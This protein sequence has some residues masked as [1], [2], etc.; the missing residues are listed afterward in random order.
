[1]T[2]I[3]NSAFHWCSELS[4]ITIPNGVSN[5]GESA[6]VDCDSLVKVEFGSN[7]KLETIDEYAFEHCGL[8]EIVIPRSVSEIEQGAFESCSKLSTVYYNGN[9]EEWDE[10]YIGSNND[11]LKN[12]TKKF[13]LYVIP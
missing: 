7:S 11:H 3:G 4:D 13:F 10:I 2:I 9:Q 5:I 1:M 8:S 6:F 12:A